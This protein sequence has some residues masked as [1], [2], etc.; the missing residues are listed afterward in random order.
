MPSVLFVCTANIAR[1]PMAA[2]I[3]RM[4]LQKTDENWQEWRIESAGTWAQE[5]LP[6]TALARKTM[7]RHGLDISTHRSRCVTGEML[8]DFDLILTMESTHK[9]ALQAEFPQ[10]IERIF[11][12]SEM[13]GRK[14]DVI[15]PMGGS[16]N[17]F[18]VTVVEIERWITEGMERI[19]V[20]VLQRE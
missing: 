2:E 19:R 8:K 13:V 10:L 1:S 3:F 16:A 17:D 7:Q 12:L 15:D 14:L 18:E 5:R 11:L 6:A 20:L 4:Q 9:E